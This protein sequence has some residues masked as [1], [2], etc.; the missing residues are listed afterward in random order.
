MFGILLYLDSLPVFF[1]LVKGAI[2]EARTLVQELR[3]VYTVVQ[4]LLEVCS[5]VQ[6]LLEVC[7]L[8]QD[9]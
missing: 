8:V 4:E 1:V 6:E 7:T 9:D 3:E 5:V 2:I